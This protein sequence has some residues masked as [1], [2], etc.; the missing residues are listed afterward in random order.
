MAG[1]NGRGDY[2]MRGVGY[3]GSCLARWQG[4]GNDHS[5]STWRGGNGEEETSAAA[6]C[7]AEAVAVATMLGGGDEAMTV[8]AQ[9]QEEVTALAVRPGDWKEATTTTWCR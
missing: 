5:G 4:G 3:D 1:A 8:A 2:P 7:G 6:R 9:R